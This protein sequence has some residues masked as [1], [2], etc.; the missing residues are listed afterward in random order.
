MWSSKATR[1]PIIE[2][3]RAVNFFCT[4]VFDQNMQLKDERIAERLTK[5]QFDGN[6]NKVNSVDNFNRLRGFR[7][8]FKNSSIGSRLCGVI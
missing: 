4:I 3:E 6:V 7:P 1:T 8:V 5:M 2:E